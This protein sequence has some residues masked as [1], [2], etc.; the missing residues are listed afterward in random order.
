MIRNDETFEVL[1]TEFFYRGPVFD[2]RKDNIKL[3]NG[4]TFQIDVIE[5]RDAITILPI[6]DQGMVW[7]V[8]Q[9]RHPARQALLELPAGVTE[10]GETPE[11]GAL[12][13]IREEIGMSADKLDRMG[14]FYIAPGYS[15]EFM[16]VFLATDL[17]PNPLPGDEDEFIRVEKLS[18]RQSMTLAETG[19]L[20]DSKS[21]V[22]LFWARPH[23]IKLGLL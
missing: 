14:G 7:F 21:L 12:R 18:A 16:H 19:Q 17:N 11:L 10:P 3:P 8:K 2:V 5:H 20:Q 23:F 15:T 13:E 22:A 6:D 4:K 9:Y 1:D